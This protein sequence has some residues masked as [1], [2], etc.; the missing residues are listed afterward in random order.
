MEVI[1]QIQSIPQEIFLCNRLAMARLDD[2]QETPITLHKLIRLKIFW[3][4][5]NGLHKVLQ[6]T[7]RKSLVISRREAQIARISPKSLSKT[8]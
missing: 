6:I 7:N 8:L 1:T 5:C 4:V 3:R 2:T